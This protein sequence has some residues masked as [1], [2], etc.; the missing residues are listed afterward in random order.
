MFVFSVTSIQYN[1]ESKYS[2]SANI[3][4][5]CHFCIS[6]TIKVLQYRTKKKFTLVRSVIYFVT[7]ILILQVQW[8]LQSWL[9]YKEAE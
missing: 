6:K 8:L 4:F 1:L 5:I 7:S 3:F 2:P 9:Y